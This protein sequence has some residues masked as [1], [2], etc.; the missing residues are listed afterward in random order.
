LIQNIWIILLIWSILYLGD[1]LLT[2]YSARN[3]TGPLS[4]HFEFERSF[5][6]NPV[7]EN[8]VNNLRLI[9]PRHIFL[10]LLTSGFLYFVWYLAGQLDLPEFFYFI[11]GQ[12]MLLEVVINQ[13]HLRNVALIKSYADGAIT[14]HIKQTYWFS[15]KQSAWEM[16]V[17]SLIYL[18][19]A[20][21]VNSWFFGGGAFG[22]LIYSFR[23]HSRSKKARKE[24]AAAQNASDN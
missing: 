1:Y 23:N 4:N 8:D 12:L 5:E 6:L 16:M 13:R 9:S 20:L 2:I 10:W 24:H 15:L 11:L 17:F 7:F 19:F 14:G 22:C 21:V 18:L 3:I